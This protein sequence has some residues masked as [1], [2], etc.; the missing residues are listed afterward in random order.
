MGRNLVVVV[1]VV[2]LH[3]NL[4][5]NVNFRTSL[6]KLILDMRNFRT[7]LIKLILDMRKVGKLCCCCA[8]THVYLYGISAFKTLT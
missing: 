6:I 3:E 5:N 1:F 8:Q 2:V 7:S 4:I